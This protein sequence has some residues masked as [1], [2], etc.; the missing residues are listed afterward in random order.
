MDQVHTIGGFASLLAGACALVFSLVSVVRTLGFIRHS[1]EASGQV[2]RLEHS[3]D[4]LGTA[5]YEDYAP[6]FSFTV[7]GGKK[8]TVTSNISSSPADFSV[9]GSVRVRYKAASPEEARI[10]TFLETWG[11]AA[12]SGLAGLFFAGFGCRLLGLLHLAQ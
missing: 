2:I 3:K 6:V 7:P 9:G 4:K 12:I 1:V 5:S 8:Y 10:H 11:A